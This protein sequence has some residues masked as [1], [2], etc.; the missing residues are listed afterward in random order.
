MKIMTSAFTSTEVRR[1][2]NGF[3]NRKKQSDTLGGGRERGWKERANRKRIHGHAPQCDDSV[4][5]GLL[6]D[7]EEG[8]RAIN[9][10]EKIQCDKK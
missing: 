4:G 7:M 2:E 3:K 9:G 8:V 6:L 10:N 5:G 1:T